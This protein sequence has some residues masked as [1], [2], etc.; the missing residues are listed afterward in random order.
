MCAASADRQLSSYDEGASSR[1]IGRRPTV[2]LASVQLLLCSPSCGPE[3]VVCTSPHRLPRAPRDKAWNG[4]PPIPPVG[5]VCVSR[6]LASMFPNMWPGIVPTPWCL[7][8]HTTE[9]LLPPH[10]F[11]PVSFIFERFN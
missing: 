7:A 6:A 1:V 9:H 3:S 8:A 10:R 2:A 11:S 4:A 5:L